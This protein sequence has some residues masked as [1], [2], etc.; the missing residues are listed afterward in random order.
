[1]AGTKHRPSH[2]NGDHQD[3]SWEFADSSSD[4]DGDSDE[5]MM[6]LDLET[7]DLKL[8]WGRK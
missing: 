5:G 6:H 2:A 1:M 4:D 8:K 3:S 7:S